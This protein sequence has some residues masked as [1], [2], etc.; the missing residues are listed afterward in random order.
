MAALSARQCAVALV[1]RA[2]RGLHGRTRRI[3]IVAMAPKLLIA[4]WRYVTRGVVPAG[5]RIAA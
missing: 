1:P 3:P 4:I 5:V 2:N